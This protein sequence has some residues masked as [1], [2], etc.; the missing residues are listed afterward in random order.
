MTTGFVDDVAVLAKGKTFAEANAKITRMMDEAQ[1]WAQRANCEFEIDKFALIGFTR[2]T[3]PKPFEPRRRQLAPRFV[4]T[5]QGKQIKPTP[6]TKFLGIKIHQSLSWAEQVSAALAKGTAWAIECKRI[7]K[8]MKGIP[9][10]YTRWLYLTVCVPRMLYAVNI[11]GALE[12]SR[13]C[14]GRNKK[15][16][17]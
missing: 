3:M 4:I 8:T 12:P 7:A 10:R 13:K 9:L 11:W 6:S 17:G 5:L 1:E 16:G 14:K 15:I 2:R